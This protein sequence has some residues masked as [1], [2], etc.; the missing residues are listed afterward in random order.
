MSY[1]SM[2][3]CTRRYQPL[4][5]LGKPCIAIISTD[6]LSGDDLSV[7]GSAALLVRCQPMTSSPRGCQRALCFHHSVGCQHT[8][9]AALP[10]TAMVPHSLEKTK[11]G[12]ELPAKP[13]SAFA[14]P[15]FYFK[16]GELGNFIVHCITLTNFL[17]LL[18]MVLAAEVRGRAPCGGQVQGKEASVHL[19]K[20]PETL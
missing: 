9:F 20:S 16:A 15:W 19:S 7:G 10:G 13:S 2:F 8:S 17:S 18:A 11:P 6:V 12:P 3:L 1:E 5:I 14:F 4:G